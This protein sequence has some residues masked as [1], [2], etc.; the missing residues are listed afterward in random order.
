MFLKHRLIRDE[1][2]ATLVEFAIVATLLFMLMFGII[3]FGLAFRDRLTVSNAAQD[4][5]R[6]GSALG[7]DSESDWEILSRLEQNIQSL[8]SGGIGVVRHVDIFRADA[9]GGVFS[10]GSCPGAYCNRYSYQPV[11]GPPCDWNPCPDPAS[12]SPSYGGSWVPGGRD[13]ALPD[14]DVMGVE[15]TF[16]HE[17]ITGGLVP[18]PNVK[19]DGSPGAGCWANTALMRLEPQIFE[20]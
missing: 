19:C 11:P 16:G 13:V 14:L 3:E 7:D 18:L 12:G 20:S 6:V 15:V 10:N 8:P 1:Q 17:W 5:V 9:D 2:G 4:A